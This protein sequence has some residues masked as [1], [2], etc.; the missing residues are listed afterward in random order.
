MKT[1]RILA[2]I[3]CCL[4]FFTACEKDGSLL[5]VL[6]LESSNLMSSEDDV[7]LTKESASTSVLALT[8]DESEL[9]LSDDSK[10]LPSSVPVVTLEVSASSSFATYEVITP[11][12]NTYSFTGAALN[13]LAKNLG[14][15]AG[16]SAPMYF[17]VNMRYGVNTE[18]YY[19]DV[20]TVDVTPYSIDMT[21]GFILS[22]DKE[23][24]GF[25][26]YSPN[27]DGEYYGFTGSSGWYNWYLL[28]GDGTMWGNLGQDGY[29]FVLSNDQATFWNFW[30][31][32]LGGCY[33]TTLSTTG[34]E[35]TA[36]YIPDLAVS[37]DVT[38]SM[39]FDK[40][41][42]KWYVSFTT[43]ADNAKIKVSCSDAKLYN[44][45]TKTDDAS[46][47][48][49]TLGFIPNADSTLSFAWNSTSAGD[50]N[51]SKAGDYTLTF[52]LSDPKKWTFQLKPGKTVI[53]EPISK[54]LYLPGIDDGTSGAWNF[55]NYLNLVSEDDSTFAGVVNI[56]SLWGY[57]MSLA[58]NYD[59]VYKMGGTAGTLLLD[60]GDNITAPSAGLYLIQADL[61]NMTYSH[62]AVTGLSY[63]GLNGDWGVT[64][65]DATSVT[66]AFAKSV[67]ITTTSQY[68]TQLLLNGDWGTYFGGTDCVLH[69]KGANI[70]DDATI[71]AGTYDLIANVCK[72]TY[73][74]AGDKLYIGGLND[75][76]DFTSVILTKTSTGVYTGTAVITATSSW[77]IKIYLY[78]DNWDLYYG[79]S[80][81][82]LSYKG[83]NITDDHSLAAGTYTVTV[84][85][86]NNTCSFVSAKKKK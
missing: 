25:K 71:G 26:L 81:S 40:A 42:V 62:T 10:S 24:T 52:Y 60:A 82:S 19:S 17:R 73:V 29:P 23:D 46:A 15:V 72:N 39:T 9:T 11:E 30:Y 70:A 58:A 16:T 5:R 4:F 79:G 43:T 74:F 32:G 53:V 80:F 12:S 56:N 2:Y 37:G 8:W 76:W 61:K 13:T 28:E 41:N 54:F 66:G 38:A 22:S 35:W 18:P 64:A 14:L 21:L 57:Q 6:G 59:H 65:M 86:L 34:K 45:T 49:K 63:A 33:Y 84:N 44:A 48:A 68:G 31:P 1:T 7:V 83:S 75:A 85:L 69:Y 67:T 50:I 77:G 3:L 51:I 55:N 20:V 27:S 47:I 78:K 36:T